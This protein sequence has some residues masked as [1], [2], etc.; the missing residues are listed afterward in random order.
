MKIYL[1]IYTFYLTDI[2]YDPQ[3][4]AETRKVFLTGDPSVDPLLYNGEFQI[5]VLEMMGKLVLMEEKTTQRMS[6]MR[7]FCRL[8]VSVYCDRLTREYRYYC[9]E[10]TRAHV[11][12]LFAS[13]DEHERLEIIYTQLSRILHMCTSHGVFN[14]P[15]P[16]P[17]L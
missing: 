16:A 7:I 17:L 4:S 8:D 10:V 14:S 15:P 11:G 1:L 6:G 3:E 9:N 12:A 5:Y 2:S 13:W